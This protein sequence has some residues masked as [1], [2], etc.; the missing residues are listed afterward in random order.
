VAGLDQRWRAG[1][2]DAAVVARV[3]ERDAVQLE[4]DVGQVVE[5]LAVVAEGQDGIGGAMPDKAAA[6]GAI[7]VV[8]VFGDQ[9]RVGGGLGPVVELD[10]GVI[11]S[12]DALTQQRK[13]II[14]VRRGPQRSE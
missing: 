12:P 13:A 4:A 10:P 11:C 7:G 14:R 8:R 3:I 5:D 2:T 6:P 9:H 1:P